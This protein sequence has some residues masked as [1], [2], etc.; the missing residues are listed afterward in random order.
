MADQS[1]TAA[2]LDLLQSMTRERNEHA[3]RLARFEFQAMIKELLTGTAFASTS[4]AATKQPVPDFPFPS[5]TAGLPQLK[6]PLG[7]V[8][9]HTDPSSLPVI[10]VLIEDRGQSTR[11]S[12]NALLHE[13]HATPFARI[14]FVTRDL[15]TVPY[16]DR[17]GFAVIC[18]GSSPVSDAGRL[19]LRRFGVQQ[20]R[21][22]KSG[23]T[24]WSD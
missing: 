12:L 7:R 17:Y 2:N 24:I 21:D 8:A 10:G 16:F 11:E 23:K 9:W 1:K 6:A 19:L 18:I 13:L 22:L 20:I 5:Q 3:I 4:G 15:G 14:V